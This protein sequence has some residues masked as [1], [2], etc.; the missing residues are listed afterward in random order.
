[1][2]FEAYTGVNDAVPKVGEQDRSADIWVWNF[3][4]TKDV[5]S[6]NQ[7][8]LLLSLCSIC[9]NE[10]FGRYVLSNGCDTV[11]VM[12]IHRGTVDVMPIEPE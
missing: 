4:A 1:M 8:W 9:G 2:W 11:D 5:Y 12:S 6:V 10:S 3:E 7:G